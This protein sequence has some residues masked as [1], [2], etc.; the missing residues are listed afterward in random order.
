MALGF[1][2]QRNTIVSGGAVATL[3][4]LDEGF[5]ADVEV[6]AGASAT[7]TFQCKIA[8]DGVPANYIYQ[9]YK[10]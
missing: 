2:T 1:I 5:P 3:P 7:A 10:T 8:E 9:W 4:V 6:A